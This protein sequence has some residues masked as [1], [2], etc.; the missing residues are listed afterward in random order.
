MSYL[1]LHNPENIII[2]GDMNVTLAINEKKGGSPIRDPAE[3]GL[4]TLCWVGSW[5][6]SSPHMGSSPGPTK[7]LA[8][9]ILLLDW[10][11]FSSNPLS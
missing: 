1:S 4:K 6:I 5:R 11:N 2:A 9:A 7:G 8:P 10:T 3:S